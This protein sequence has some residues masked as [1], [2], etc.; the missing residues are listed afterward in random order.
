MKTKQDR[1]GKIAPKL[2][3]FR[4]CINLIRC[5]PLLQYDEKNPCDAATEPHEI[6]HITDALRYFCASWTY[7][8][9]TPKEAIQRSILE[10]MF[11]TEKANYGDE[12]DF[13]S[14]E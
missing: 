13:I 4:N 11:K 9:V 6:T 1:E 14:W 7:P 5:L 2:R 12:G 8:P 3:I 10:R